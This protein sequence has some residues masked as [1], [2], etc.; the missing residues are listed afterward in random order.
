MHLDRA[1]GFLRQRDGQRL[2][3]DQRLA[4]EAAADL[5]RI[6]PDVGHVDAQ[7]LGGVGADHEL[8]LAGAVDLHL[9]V[10]R[11]GRQAGMRLDI[12]LV[13]RLGGVVALDDH[14]GLGEAGLDVALGEGHDLGDVGRLGRLRLD[15][16]GEHVV[17]QQ[18][19]AV[20][21]RLFDV[22]DVRQHL[23]LAPRSAPAPPRRSAWVA[24]ATAA[25][26][27]PSY[28]TLSR[29]MTFRDRSRK[30]I[31]PSPTK[32]SSG[33]MSGKSAAVTT[34]LHARQRL[35]LAG[36]DRDDPGMRVRG[37]QDLAP[38]HPGRA[39]RRRTPRGR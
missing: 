26:A 6:H 32:A 14:L 17:V 1:A 23:V 38:Q 15:A 18:R 19:R 20:G 34:A 7:Q 10:R 25:S 39:C 13:H 2:E 12:G 24:A 28:S 11:R 35:G 21:H 36:V 37:A 33:G 5:G 3:I 8:A 29:A 31:G 4:A 30:F 27:W 22:D 9:A 16:G